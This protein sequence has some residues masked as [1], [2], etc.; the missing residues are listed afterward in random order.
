MQQHTPMNASR[1]H[2]A[3]QTIRASNPQAGAVA[4]ILHLRVFVEGDL[5]QLGPRVMVTEGL[6]ER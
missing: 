2:A 6:A 4:S 3:K 5:K 1:N